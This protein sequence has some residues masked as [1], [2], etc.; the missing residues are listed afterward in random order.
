MC[1]S[2]VLALMMLPSLFIYQIY[3]H[4]P[5]HFI[6]D[7]GQFT[8]ILKANNWIMNHLPANKQTE[9]TEN[10][11][12]QSLATSLLLYAINMLIFVVDIVG[13]NSYSGFSFGYLFSCISSRVTII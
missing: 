5:F 12:V 11:T 6:S 2:G 4:D 13:L 10:F 9:S 1:C 3:L 8:I 7:S